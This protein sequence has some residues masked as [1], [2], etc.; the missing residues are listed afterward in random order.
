ML[1]VCE[2]DFSV[3]TLIPFPS[4]VLSIIGIKAIIINKQLCKIESVCQKRKVK[5]T[6]L[7][8]GAVVFE[9]FGDLAAGKVAKVGRCWL[10]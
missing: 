5:N 2:A 6:L 7:T 4:V 1:A 9:G 3:T 8:H 10:S